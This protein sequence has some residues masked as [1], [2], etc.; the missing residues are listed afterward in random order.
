MTIRSQGWTDHPTRVARLRWHHPFVA[1]FDLLIR[2]GT[3][4]DGTGTPGRPADLGIIGDR[5]LAIGDLSG[6]D[7]AAAPT[8]I[9]AAGSA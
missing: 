7:G 3:L 1:S 8:V 6:L 2:G 9:D 5:I 4:V